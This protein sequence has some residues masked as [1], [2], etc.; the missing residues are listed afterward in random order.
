MGIIVKGFSFRILSA[1]GPS[2]GVMSWTFFLF[3]FTLTVTLSSL[4]RPCYGQFTDTT[5]AILKDYKQHLDPTTE[6]SGRLGSVDL[7]TTND[8]P[9]TYGFKSQNGSLA[10]VTDYQT[11]PH[12]SQNLP[13]LDAK[14][15]RLSPTVQCN[16]DSMT[17]RVKRGKAPHFLVDGGDGSPVLPLSRMPTHCGFSVK[18]LRRDVMFVA[19]YKGCH[20][21]Q[22]GGNYVL[23]LRLW[24]AT[25]TMSCPV[26]PP[27]P[28]VS[29]FSSGMVVKLPMEAD[30]LKVKVSGVWEHLFYAC[31]LCGITIESF[32]GGTVITAPYNGPCIMIEANEHLLSLLSAVGEITLTCPMSNTSMKRTTHV[33]VS[34]TVSPLDPQG[35][36]FPH[37][38]QPRGYPQA[39]ERPGKNLF[40]R[41]PYYLFKYP[42]VPTEAPTSSN[43]PV[44]ASEAPH[45]RHRGYPFGQDGPEYPW[46]HS[47]PEYPQFMQV[48]YYLSQYP[49]NP[50]AAPT[51]SNSPVPASKPPRVQHRGSPRGQDRPE[52]SWGQQW[53]EYQKPGYP[54]MR[55]V[56]DFSHYDPQMNVLPAPT[57]RPSTTA[58]TL[59]KSNVPRSASKAPHVQPRGFN[60]VNQRPYFSDKR[61]ANPHG[62]PYAFQPF[63]HYPLLPRSATPP[64]AVGS[65]AT[66]TTQV[67]P[68]R[69]FRPPGQYPRAYSWNPYASVFHSDY[70]VPQY[71]YPDHK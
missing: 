63:D 39:Q 43:S 4:V 42:S 27:T 66:A 33:P 37:G 18:R 67:Q 41:V 9:A 6:R 36:N 40:Q 25:M 60:Q 22:Q 21:T 10:F 28:S 35:L 55:Q 16:N 12:A 38:I 11:H 32:S 49:S 52:Y 19:P 53:P 31:Q 44:P 26:A 70:E 7:D 20:I 13:Q 24:G 17:L 59:E 68:E 15:Q 64:A 71:P 69:S 61:R 8:E 14:L 2:K 29:C 48:P 3:Y 58:A 30:T 45:V 56:H 5:T 23:P 46:G 51:R 47:R 62:H 54:L 57:T 1:A 34:D 50:T 65:S